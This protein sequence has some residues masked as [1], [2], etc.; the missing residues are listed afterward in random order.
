[1]TNTLTGPTATFTDSPTYT[2]TGTPTFTCTPT[3]TNTL[4]GPTSTFTNT[5]TATQTYTVTLTPTNTYTSTVTN[6]PTLTST[7]SN[8]VTAT[9]TTT[10]TN[11]QTK[12]STPTITYTPTLTF[13]PT[14]TSTASPTAINIVIY[15]PPYPNPVTTGPVEIDV[16]TPGAATIQMDVFTTAFRKISE[17]TFLA[18]GGSGPLGTV[19]AVQWDIRDKIGMNVADGLYYV[20]IQ[21]SGRQDS[22]KIFKVLVLR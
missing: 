10:V 19:T 5:F 14:S 6:T 16:T 18:G 7:N 22:V 21:V 15:T 12:T 4:S 3:F 1:M 8:T 9:Q 17:H 11:T 13:T 20:R 2:Y